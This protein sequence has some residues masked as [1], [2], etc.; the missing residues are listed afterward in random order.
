MRLTKI[1]Y[2]CFL[3]G[4]CMAVIW[5]VNAYNTFK[6]KFMVSRIENI[7]DVIN[8]LPQSPQDIRN[9]T[10]LYLKEMQEDIEELLGYDVLIRTYSNT[11]RSFD[12]LVGLSN[13]KIWANILQ[14]TELTHPNEEM[15]DAARQARLSIDAFFDE[16]V[17]GNRQLFNALQEYDLSK[18]QKDP[19]DESQLYMLKELLADYLRAGVN[20]PEQQSKKVIALRKELT[21]LES[22]FAKN[23]ADSNETL[24]VHENDLQG[25]P[26]SWLQTRERTTDGM[27]TLG[28]DY[29][30]YFMVIENCAVEK[31]R[32]DL[33]LL[34]SNRGY[35]ANDAVL[36]KVIQKRH[37]LAIL[38][39]FETYSDLNLDGTMAKNQQ[40]VERFLKE[41][42][43][44]SAPKQEKEL[45]LWCQNLPESVTLTA[46]GK[47][48]QWDSRF[49]KN[50]Y[51][52]QYLQIDEY[53][54]AQYFPMEHTIQELLNIY[55][56][57]MSLEFE[58]V[59][60]EGLWHD[61]VRTLVVMNADKTVVYGYLFLDLYPRANK[62][63]HAGC[64]PMSPAIRAEE[65]LLAR[66][67]AIGAVIANFPPAS[68]NR[69]ALLRLNDVRTYFH[70]F[71][72]ALHLLLSAT[73]MA[74]FSGMHVKGDFVEMPSQMLEEWLWDEGVLAKI[75]S[76]YQ[77]GEPLSSEMIKK[78]IAL[79]QFDAGNFV[80]GQLSL[81][82]YSLYLF[83]GLTDPAEIAKEVHFRYD[84]AFAYEPE[85]HWYAA[86]THLMGYGA[87]YYGY[88]W[89]RVFALDMFSEI[90][91]YGLYDPVVGKRYVDEVLALGGSY[92]PN[93]LLEN[94]LGRKPEQDAFLI[95]FGFKNYA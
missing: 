61:T 36:K 55:R 42:A 95:A 92:D 66:I 20:L 59:P 53:E 37:E 17:K 93:D 39:G 62:F 19:L 35:P 84:D 28:G 27:Y 81:S 72:H 46:D 52:K 3:V 49:I 79:K 88:L 32:K 22:E 23:I 65:L 13:V 64:A 71:G 80:Q 31:T 12:R 51:K 7:E 5:Y 68:G 82:F 77:T 57:F 38:L 30:T 18:E 16:E 24:Q 48:K 67:P 47:I 50:S 26:A 85:A 43:V 33:F 41:L 63:T 15:R 56:Q 70:E 83:R 69:P 14:V 25:V 86:V 60:C 89:S 76:H 45:A 90:K 75:S 91:R 73:R 40:T 10:T 4:I 8:L 87:T 54:I 2:T 21:E 78:I 1:I 9:R 34:F 74:T 11:V 58:E 6:K 29:P 44:R 94:F